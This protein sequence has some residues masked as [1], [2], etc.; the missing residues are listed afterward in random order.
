MGDEDVLQVGGVAARLG[1]E[2]RTAILEAATADICIMAW[3][4]SKLSMGNW[5]V[6][7]PF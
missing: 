4:S 1:I 7:H 2:V 5:S 3:M 6:S